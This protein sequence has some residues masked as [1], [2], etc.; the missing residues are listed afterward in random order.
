MS[1]VDGATLIARS[2]KQQGINHLFGVV[3]FPVGPIAAAAQKE[4][5]AY[6]GMRNEQAASYAARAYGYLTGRPGACIV[7]TGPGVVHGLA[8]LADAQQ[9]CW[10]MILIGGASETYRRGMGAFQEER[11]VLLAAPLC[12][13]A[14]AIDSVK[15]IPY[16]VAEATRN[17]TYG[18]PGAAYLD[19]PDDII[20][21]KCDEK[22]VVQ[23][24]KCPD[25]PRFQ[26]PPENIDAALNM[27]E[28]AERP[29]I[30]VGKGMAWA[31]A[32]S[33]VRSFIEKTQVPFLRSPMGKGVMPDDH[34]LSVAAARTLALQNAD[35]VFLM[36]ARFNW[37]MHFG[38]PPR[39]SKDVRVIQLD[40]S[41]EAMHQNK[42]AEVALVGDGKAIVGQLNQALASRQWFYP[43]ETP[44]RAA[45]AKKSAENAAMIAPQIADDSAPGGYY[46]LL[47]DVAAWVPKNAI[48]CSEGA[49]TMDIGRTQ[50]PN[51][52]PRSRLDAGS[53]GTMG[54]GLGIV[55]A[56]CVV[57][58]DKP[59]IHVSG[60][61]AIGFS[62]ME[63]ET[64]CRYGMPAKIVVFNNGGIGPGMPE[65]PNN[66]MLNM[67]PN[68]L[69]WGARYD[70]M[71][72]AFGGY[73][74]Y[75]E[76]PKDLRAAL[77]EAM[78]TPGPALVNVK[79]SLGSQRKA[80][81][82]RWHS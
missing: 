48:I 61:S 80:Q 46:R 45:I 57:H 71:M 25:P 22:D 31:N 27:L 55:I 42:P 56:A 28:R 13:F 43:K 77:D 1:E 32:E 41:R 17:A 24:Q 10:P 15:R 81:E 54:V 30:L 51:Y 68:S 59:I 3:G 53:Y 14:H 33:E 8:G 64:L 69:I 82:F 58:P 78:R 37:I 35:V 74:A 20:T 76:D 70:L 23:V 29:L 6:I 19:M 39:Y 50:L 2:L 40:I 18:R 16:Y 36:G 79:L 26:A 67:R 65:I 11:Q 72:E 52:N 66:P 7:V 62:G 75:V 4:G 44:W 38:L 9:N 21:G 49:S 73:G 63:M 47:R 34:P 12:K 5:V 60:D